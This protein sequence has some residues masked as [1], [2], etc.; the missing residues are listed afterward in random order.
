MGIVVKVNVDAMDLLDVC[1]YPLGPIF[2]GRFAVVAIISADC[3]VKANVNH[4]AG[5]D[6]R[7]RDAQQIVDAKAYAEF[8]KQVVCILRKPAFVPEF[9]NSLPAFRQ[10]LQKISQPI[11]V[12]VEAGRQLIK[13]RAE[14]FLQQLGSLKKAGHRF[15][16]VF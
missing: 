9:K 4:I 14:T 3:A 2:E 11:N 16:S 6:T 7:R 8:V 10:K 13:D 1:F 15:F 5:Y 12:F